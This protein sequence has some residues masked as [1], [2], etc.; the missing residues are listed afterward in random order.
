[1]GLSSRG[2]VTWTPNKEAH[3]FLVA[4]DVVGFSKSLNDPDEL[5]LLRRGLQ[6]VVERSELVARA[7]RDD[8][9]RFH[10]LGDELRLAFLC[11]ACEAR[12]VFEFIKYLMDATGS[13]SRRQQ[14]PDLRAVTMQ[15]QVLPREWHGCQYLAGALVRRAQRWASALAACEFALEDKFHEALGRRGLPASWKQ[16]SFG[17]EPG[18]VSK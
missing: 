17:G 6:H 15:G 4:L 12:E 8:W 16:R 1:M 5:L 3:C 9:M 2:G 13:S 10:F 7:L 14:C 18:W 11:S